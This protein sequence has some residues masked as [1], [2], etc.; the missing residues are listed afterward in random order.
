MG[1]TDVLCDAIQHC[2]EKH[3]I[4]WTRDDL[5]KLEYSGGTA[6]VWTKWQG[7]GPRW[8]KYMP[9]GKQG[10]HRYVLQSGHPRIKPL[11][12]SDATRYY[13]FSHGE[14]SDDDY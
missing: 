1:P 13:D 14:T 10:F 7:G 3:L 2:F 12:P 8:I 5:R 11:F 6:K 4:D 9:S